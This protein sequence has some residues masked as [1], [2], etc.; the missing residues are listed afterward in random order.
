MTEQEIR[1]DLYSYISDEYKGVYG[2][3]PRHINPNN[4]TIEELQVMVDGLEQEVISHNEQRREQV[5]SNDAEFEALI[6]TVI[7]HG[8]P[9][10]VA[11]I[12]WLAD[13]AST[14]WSDEF[15]YKYDIS[16]SYKP[17]IEAAIADKWN[18]Q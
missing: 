6:K 16:F 13:S 14:D 8:A 15:I 12:R 3:R 18:I 2:T 5:A 7:K 11:A 17:E 9:D 10:R 1:D 4:Y